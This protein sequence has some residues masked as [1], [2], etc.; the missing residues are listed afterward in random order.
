MSRNRA[1]TLKT[2]MKSQTK[3]GRYVQVCDSILN[4]PTPLSSRSKRSDATT[5]LAR[6]LMHYS[7]PLFAGRAI[8]ILQQTL[9]DYFSKGL[10]SSLEIPLVNQDSLPATNG[11]WLKNALGLSDTADS[12]RETKTHE[13]AKAKEEDDTG[14]IYSPRVR[15]TYTPPIPLPAPFPKT[16]HVEGLHLYTASSV[17]LR[18]TMN[19]LYT[20]LHVELSRVRVQGPGARPPRNGEDTLTQIIH[21]AST[22]AVRA[23]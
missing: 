7:T 9:P 20:D 10:V 4:A 17:F 3:S 6:A 18:H 2:Q 23:M 13:K 14:S 12:A 11:S 22:H 5:R 21:P 19:A 16:L 1:R 8:Y 15:L